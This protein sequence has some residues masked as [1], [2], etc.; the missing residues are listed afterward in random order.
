[1]DTA[2][3]KVVAKQRLPIAGAMPQDVKISPNGKTWYIADMVANGVWVLNGDTFG[4]P[5]L[6]PTGKGTHG[7]YVSRDGRLRARIPVGGGPHGLA[8]YPQPGR[9]SLGHTGIFR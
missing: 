2:K 3:K 6:L 1:M 8:V 9:Y 4:K 5:R 7:L